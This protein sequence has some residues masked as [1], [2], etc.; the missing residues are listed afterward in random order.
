MRN[1]E[2]EICR[3]AMAQR[4]PSTE[5]RALLRDVRMATRAPTVDHSRPVSRVITPRPPIDRPGV[6]EWIVTRVVRRGQRST[7]IH[8]RRADPG[9]R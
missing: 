1:P 7:P 3:R 9:S 5:V 8:Q 4:L 6:R 2:S